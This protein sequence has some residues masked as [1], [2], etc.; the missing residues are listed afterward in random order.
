[1]TPPKISVLLPVHNAEK[2]LIE[3]LDSLI[4][5]TFSDFEIIAIDDASTDNSLHRLKDYAQRDGRIKVFHNETNLKL[6]KTLNKG[7]CLAQAP[8][9]A[10]MDADDIALPKR[11]E[12]QYKFMKNNP[13][14]DVCGAWAQGFCETNRRYSVPVDHDTI[15]SALPFFNPMIHPTVMIRTDVARNNLYDETFDRSQD[16]ELWARMLLTGTSKFHNIP[17]VLLLYRYKDKKSSKSFYLNTK[18]NI[19]SMILKNNLT[20]HDILINEAISNQ[21][22]NSKDYSTQEIKQWLI[23]LIEF[24]AQS[25]KIQSNN[26]NKM[27][28]FI[29]IQSLIRKRGIKIKSILNTPFITNKYKELIKYIIKKMI[30]EI[31]ILHI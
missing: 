15:C 11:F 7:I 26:L 1:M 8:L 23:K 2:Y 13:D 28:I 10:R 9:I 12:I 14:I 6:A 5:Q 25:K 31:K 19:L 29:F 24:N 22:T 3:C 17:K 18:I 4:T 27:A 30:Y 16:Y 21:G 20:E